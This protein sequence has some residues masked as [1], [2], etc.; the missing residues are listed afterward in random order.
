V[1]CGH[2]E[3][4]RSTLTYSAG[5]IGAGDVLVLAALLARG[6]QNRPDLSG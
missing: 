5:K 4:R 2:A 6:I 1:S 3:S